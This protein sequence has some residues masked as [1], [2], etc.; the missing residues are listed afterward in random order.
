MDAAPTVQ[1]PPPPPPPLPR[2]NPFAVLICFL[3]PAVVFSIVA[4]RVTALMVVGTDIAQLSPQE[5]FVL[6]ALVDVPLI[7]GTLLLARWLLRARPRDLGF[8]PL[9]WADISYG[10]KFGV[11]LFAASIAVGLIQ[12]AVFGK[13]PQDIAQALAGHTGL[14]AF[15]LDFLAISVLTP[16]A[17]ELLFR[18]LLFGALRQRFPFIP[19]AVAAA[20]LFTLPHEPQA[21][22]GVFLLGF[23]LALAYERTR[24]LWAPIVTHA[25]I[26]AIPLLLLAVAGPSIL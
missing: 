18:G 2:W 3:V 7:L 8:L 17:E 15:F 16:V 4:M 21:Y 1:P 23:G 22:P 11:G 13:E 20:I 26:N 5:L 14:E 19:A 9:R 10:L 6:V 24:T 25:T 12:A